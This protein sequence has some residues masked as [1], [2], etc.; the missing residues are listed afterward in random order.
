MSNQRVATRY[1]KSLIEL[2]EERGK[3]EK[4]LEDMT[5]FREVAKN[6][7]FGL[8]LKS[9]IIKA[10][11]KQQIFKKLFGE[12][13]DELTMAFLNILL[14]KGRESGLVEIVDAFID[15]YKRR[16]RISTV[17]LTTAVKL[18]DSAVE[19]IRQKLIESTATDKKVELMT[20]VDPGLVGGFVI[21]FED[22]LYNA[23]VAHKLALLK[24][25]FKDNLYISQIIAQ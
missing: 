13:S 2:A 16:K 12:K 8:M 10:D 17:S 4:V 14:R 1:A 20:K 3:L 9:P 21:E 25:E 23:S 5:S 24:K 6:K 15:Q 19:A 11:K 22:R 18:S 7:E